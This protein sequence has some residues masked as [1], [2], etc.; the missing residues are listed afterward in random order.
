M[1]ELH[2]TP[3]QVPAHLRGAYAGTKFKAASDRVVIHAR[4]VLVFM[5]VLPAGSFTGL[6]HCAPSL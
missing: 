3:D 1:Q 6:A 2:L 5:C 4:R